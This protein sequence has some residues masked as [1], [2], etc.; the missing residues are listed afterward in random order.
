MAACLPGALVIQRTAV[1]YF[2]AAGL[3]VLMLGWTRGV[4]RVIVG[5]AL[6][7]HPHTEPSRHTMPSSPS[8]SSSSALTD[9][10][11]A[12]PLRLLASGL[13]TASRW[14]MIALQIG[15]GSLALFFFGGAEEAE[16]ERMLGKDN[17]RSLHTE[18]SE[19][20]ASARHTSLSSSSSS[21]SISSSVLLEQER[22]DW[23]SDD[24][25]NKKVGLLVFK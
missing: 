16:S 3:W 22:H 21:S 13:L 5:E 4:P 12:D 14:T 9:S 10:A 25:F 24:V 6:I 8:S 18:S 7:P 11:D 17:S 19:H 15:L 20:R 23:T 1:G 2:W